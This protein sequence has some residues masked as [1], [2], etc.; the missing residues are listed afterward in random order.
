V[1]LSY[2]HP[3]VQIV[4]SLSAVYLL[5]L[6]SFRFRSLHLGRK[7]P[8]KRKRHINL[9]RPALV[10]MIL[11]ALGGLLFVRWSWYGWLLTGPHGYL[12]LIAVPLILFGLVSGWY[13]AARPKARKTLPLLH[14]LGNTALVIIVLV[15]FYLGKEVIDTM[16]R[17]V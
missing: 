3:L 11:G 14:A 12:G 10:V 8:F 13:M 6:G 2:I 15:Q 7:V 17:G 9:G 1:W 5:Y 16:I 4:V